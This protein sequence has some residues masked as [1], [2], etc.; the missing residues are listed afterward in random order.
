MPKVETAVFKLDPT[1]QGLPPVP[2]GYLYVKRGDPSSAIYVPAAKEEPH[3][4]KNDMQERH[5]AFEAWKALGG[6]YP[7][8][9]DRLVLDIAFKAGWEAHKNRRKKDTVSR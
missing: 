3:M 1:K 7:P 2:D 4:K 6:T 5:E 8:G 9:V